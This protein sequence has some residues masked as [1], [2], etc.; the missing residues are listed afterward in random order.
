MPQISLLAIATFRAEPGH[1]NGEADVGISGQ[2][3]PL[4]ALLTLPQP[5]RKVSYLQSRK[6]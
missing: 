2:A 4:A 1:S 6:Q 5:P 3:D